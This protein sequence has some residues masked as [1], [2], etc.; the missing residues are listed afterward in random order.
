MEAA[1]Q[2]GG[3][4]VVQD[5]AKRLQVSEMELLHSLFDNYELAATIIRRKPGVKPFAPTANAELAECNRK[6]AEYITKLEACTA[7]C[8]AA[9]AEHVKALEREN[10]ELKRELTK[11]TTPKRG[12]EPEGPPPPAPPRDGNDEES[13]STPIPAPPPLPPVVVKAQGKTRVAAIKS[14]RAETKLEKTAQQENPEGNL[15]K[16]LSAA[17]ADRRRAVNGDNET[18]NGN[19]DSDWD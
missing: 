1:I 9:N 8:L 17:M 10:A 11:V 2:A 6:N 7:K 4:I 14:S 5:L 16:S 3:T 13:Q 15:A 19:D 12:E 18:S